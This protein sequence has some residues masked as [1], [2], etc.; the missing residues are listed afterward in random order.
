[1]N[2]DNFLAVGQQIVNKN[3]GTHKDPF[4][5]LGS[6]ESRQPLPIVFPN[7]RKRFLIARQNFWVPN[8][9]VMNEDIVQY[10]GGKLN[11]NEMHI[12][13]CNISYLTVGDNLIPDNIVNTILPRIKA[14][15][16]RQLLRWIIAEEANHIESYLY[17]L[18]SF[19][20]DESAQGEIFD[21]YR[22]IPAIREKVNW[23]IEYSAK[24]DNTLP[25]DDPTYYRA[26]IE[27]LVAY[28][29]FEYVFF[30]AGFSQIF[31]LARTGKLKNT[32]Q[33]YSYI[34]RDETL[35][36]G[37]ALF[38]IRQLLHKEFPDK[39]LDHDMIR[40]LRALIDEGVQLELKHNNEV[41]YEGVEGY[42]YADYSQYVKYLA[43]RACNNLGLMPLYGVTS[44]PIPWINAYQL[45]T[46]TN[47]F[48]GRVRE[49]KTGSTLRFNNL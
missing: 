49:Y 26:L 19:G 35:H 33:Q 27:N 36:G 37:N 1:M 31:G 25:S 5:I 44:N 28:Y 32:A 20:L 10:Q 7:C 39:V 21:L 9:I 40:A 17:V 12:F 14:P 6:G 34:L 30:P 29:I 43:D 24:I 42:S 15:E 38:I 2:N 3:I 13:K 11:D 45:H 16:L 41:F 18:E 23:N 46:E 47:F 4:I 48:E 8:E 22:K